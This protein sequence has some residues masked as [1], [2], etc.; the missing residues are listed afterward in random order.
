MCLPLNDTQWFDFIVEKD[1]TFQTVQCKFTSSQDNA[2]I[3]TS[4]G[5][6]DGRKYDSILNHP[7]DILFCAD[8]EKN[9]YVIPV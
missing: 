6:T 5:G 8:K 7:V 9:M 2:V 4:S 3:L 1:N